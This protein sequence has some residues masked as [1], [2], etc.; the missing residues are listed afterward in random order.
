MIL[1]PAQDSI[2]VSDKVTEQSLNIRE[3]SK[4]ALKYGKI[5]YL[6]DSDEKG[7]YFI[8]VR[9]LNFWSYEYMGR[10]ENSCTAIAEEDRETYRSLLFTFPIV[11]WVYAGG[12]YNV[13]VTGK[14]LRWDMQDQKFQ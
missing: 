3:L 5:D 4:Y 11:A 14:K 7:I 12:D 2:A 9:Q 1:P 10:G 13:P 8:E 6:R